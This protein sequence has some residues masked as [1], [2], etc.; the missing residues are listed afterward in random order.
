MRGLIFRRFQGNA[1]G[2]LKWATLKSAWDKPESA[3]MENR[4]V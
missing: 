2:V 1:L 4:N 3:E